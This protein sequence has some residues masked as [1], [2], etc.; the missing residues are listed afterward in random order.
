[1]IPFPDIKPYIIKIGPLQIRW[2]SLMYLIG[3]ICSYLLVK[4]Q[5]KKKKLPIKKQAV[6]DVYFYLFLGLLIGA[7][8]GYVLF[9]NFSE[10]LRDPLEINLAL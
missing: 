9:Y 6:D 8:L 2:Y 1:M 10:Y 3:F 4:F 5:I 7:R